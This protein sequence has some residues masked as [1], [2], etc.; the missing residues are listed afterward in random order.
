[1]LGTGQAFLASRNNRKWH[2]S[3]NFIC[4]CNNILYKYLVLFILCEVNSNLLGK[5]AVYP[6]HRLPKPI[7]RCHIWRLFVSFVFWLAFW[8]VG[9]VKQEQHTVFK[10][11]QF[12]KL[13]MTIQG[14]S[15]RESFCEWL[16]RER[17]SIDPSAHILY[18]RPSGNHKLWFVNRSANVLVRVTK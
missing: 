3:L 2:L 16:I 9:N 10:L 5:K 18:S 6:T 1:M 7:R 8:N 11:F 4:L 14:I 15:Q 17:I 13:K 12:L